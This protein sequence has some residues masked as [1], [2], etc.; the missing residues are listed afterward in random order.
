MNNRQI[1]SDCENSK[2]L[3]CTTVSKKYLIN[4]LKFK[5]Q[6]YI[7]RPKLPCK[8]CG[9]T[10]GL[11]AILRLMKNDKLNSGRTSQIGKKQT[12][13]DFFLDGMNGLTKA[14]F[15]NLESANP[16]YGNCG[17]VK[18]KVRRLRVSLC[19]PQEGGTEMSCSVNLLLMFIFKMRFCRSIGH[20]DDN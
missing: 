13:L 15:A 11:Y 9:L 16:Q 4:P 18:S 1:I 19:C 3:A 10:T 14:K 6:I 12:N 8:M 5:G 17:S 20:A 7:W 2:V